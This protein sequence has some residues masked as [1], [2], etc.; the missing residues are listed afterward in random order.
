MAGGLRHGNASPW[1]MSG[2]GPV[3]NPA[4]SPEWRQAGGN[5]MLFEQL[6]EQKMM[7]AQQKA[8][9][10]QQKAIQKQAK[11]FQKWL[12]ENQAREAKG[13]PVDPQYTLMKRQQQAIAAAP[14]RHAALVATK[15]R[16]KSTPKDT[17][18]PS[19]NRIRVRPQPVPSPTSD[20]GPDRSRP[21]LPAA[22]D[23]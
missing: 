19:P 17:A 12:K 4:L 5:P 6:M 18:V 23:L 13:Q 14:A 10:E 3:F 20:A 16:H 1:A 11:A 21:A 2:E 15:K 7:M 9:A 8:M 22:T